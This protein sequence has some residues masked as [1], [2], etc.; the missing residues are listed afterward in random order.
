MR[1]CQILLRKSCTTNTSSR[2]G[3]L[4]KLR[5]TTYFVIC[6]D[7]SAYQLVLL[8]LLL[9]FQ[10][11]LNFLIFLTFFKNLLCVTVSLDH[12]KYLFLL[13]Y[14]T[15]VNLLDPDAAC[16]LSFALDV[17]DDRS[18]VHRSVQDPGRSVGRRDRRSVFGV[19]SQYSDQT[20]AQTPVIT[21]FEGS[22]L[23]KLCDT[24]VF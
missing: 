5:F 24:L 22:G 8:S 17:G 23:S 15:V 3:S 12:L 14:R 1:Q 9:C 10:K 6:E 7:F 21:Y 18:H 16:F 20:T 19:D 11:L 4:V 2:I 13:S